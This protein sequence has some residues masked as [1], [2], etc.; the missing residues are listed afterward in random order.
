MIK[1]RS[2]RVQ[3]YIS[4]KTLKSVSKFSTFDAFNFTHTHTQSQKSA[5]SSH[6]LTIC[7]S[8]NKH[9]Y[10][11][12]GQTYTSTCMHALMQ[13]HQYH[14]CIYQVSSTVVHAYM[15]Q[16]SRINTIHVFQHTYI[17][18]TSAQNKHFIHIS[19]SMHF[20]R[21]Q[22]TIT[23]IT[24]GEKGKMVRSDGYVT[25][26]VWTHGLKIISIFRCESKLHIEITENYGRK[27]MD[28]KNL[29]V[30]DDSLFVHLLNKVLVTLTRIYTTQLTKIRV[31]KSTRNFAQKHF[32]TQEK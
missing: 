19:L 18:R 32:N 7:I 2:N 5:R 1:K 28:I 26:Q 15:Y 23:F 9:I 14:A 30:F 3:S 17:S 12:K 21:Q 22:Y 20:I 25:N 24:F 29:I 11:Y 13:R 16:R 27:C 8:M 6:A 31:T 10:V 4:N